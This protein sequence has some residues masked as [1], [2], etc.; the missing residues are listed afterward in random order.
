MFEVILF[1]CNQPLYCDLTLLR[2]TLVLFSRHL[3]RRK[4][5]KEFLSDRSLFD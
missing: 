2:R 5:Q 1:F 4:S 3:K